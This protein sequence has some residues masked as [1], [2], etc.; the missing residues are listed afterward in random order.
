M[1]HKIRNRFTKNVFKEFRK[2]GVSRELKREADKYAKD[3]MNGGKPDRGM[4]IGDEGIYGLI[5]R[6]YIDGRQKTI[7]LEAAVAGRQVA[8]RRARASGKARR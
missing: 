7:S 4:G 8:V 6:T 5:L 1:F 3:L 2:R